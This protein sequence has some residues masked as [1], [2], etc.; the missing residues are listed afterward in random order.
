[1][2]SLVCILTKNYREIIG[3][4][5]SV[6]YPLPFQLCAL[7]WFNHEAGD[8]M[9][10]VRYVS[11]GKLWTGSGVRLNFVDRCSRLSFERW[12]GELLSSLRR[13][14]ICGN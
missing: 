11:W 13:H 1:M 5:T 8:L 2:C 3:I 7:S 14:A 10:L 4:M 6:H 9:R 12:R